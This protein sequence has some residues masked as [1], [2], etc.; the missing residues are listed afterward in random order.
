VAPPPPP[1]PPPPARARR[2]PMIA[3]AAG[4]GMLILGGVLFATSETD[5]GT[6]PEYRDTKPLGVGVGITGAI[7]LGAGVALWLHT[8]PRDGGLFG[9]LDRRG[10]LIGWASAF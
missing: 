9:T 4:A 1:P 6:K 5:D 3:M 2:V 7:V 10:G 8:A